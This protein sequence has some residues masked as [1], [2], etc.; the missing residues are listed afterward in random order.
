MK[1]IK[2]LCLL[3]LCFLGGFLY[4]LVVHA[5]ERLLSIWTLI[6]ILGVLFLIYFIPLAHRLF[7][8]LS[9]ARKYAAPLPT[10]TFADRIEEEAQ[11]KR[12]EEKEKEKKGPSNA[13]DILEQSADIF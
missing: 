10:L 2:Y 11:I 7:K 9:N 4:A 8:Q 12:E 6:A 1:I 5:P 3:F 13:A